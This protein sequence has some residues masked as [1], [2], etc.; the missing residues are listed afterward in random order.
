M[1]DPETRER[2]AKKLR[3]PVAKI[4]YEN[5]GAF[6]LKTINPKKTEYKRQKLNIRKIT[7]EEEDAY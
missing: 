2:R 6:A 1:S 3:N 5:K 7:E 4:I